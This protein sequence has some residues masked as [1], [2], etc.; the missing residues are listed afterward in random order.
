VQNRW[1][2]PLPRAQLPS[3]KDAARRETAFDEYF[4]K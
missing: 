3:A 4:A 1:A 2:M